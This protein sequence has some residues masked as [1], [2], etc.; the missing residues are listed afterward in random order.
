MVVAGVFLGAAGAVAPNL[1]SSKDKTSEAQVP[2]QTSVPE[3]KVLVE[4]T[5]DIEKKY[6]TGVFAHFK[7]AEEANQYLQDQEKQAGYHRDTMTLD[8]LREH[9]RSE[10]D[11]R[12]RTMRIIISEQMFKNF[13]L[14][15]K[16][17]YA[18]LK[19]QVEELNTIYKNAG[20]DL[21]YTM[22]QIIVIDW[23]VHSATINHMAGDGVSISDTEKIQYSWQDDTTWPIADDAE[24]DETDQDIKF[25]LRPDGNYHYPTLMH[26]WVHHTGMNDLY[27]ETGRFHEKHLE[28]IWAY[29]SDMMSVSATLT[30]TPASTLAINKMLEQEYYGPQ[31]A[32]KLTFGEY[33]DMLWNYTAQEYS[34]TLQDKN[35]NRLNHLLPGGVFFTGEKDKANYFTDLNYQGVETSDTTTILNRVDINKHMHTIFN[36]Q[37]LMVPLDRRHLVYENMYRQS[38]DGPIPV[39]ITVVADPSEVG[40]NT[41][42]SLEM[43]QVGNEQPEEV[44]FNKPVIA[45]API[46]NTGIYSVWLRG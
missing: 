13:M 38:G 36:I 19:N 46:G 43:I 42:V 18:H 39:T 37:E 31:H 15:G 11:H 44:Y 28:R 33:H 32:D 22:Q 8:E 29:V 45:Y 26:E 3:V 30:L 9:R 5:R 7:T 16:D 24:N 4:P 6:E 1:L 12:H 17:P 40:T 25:I 14:L 27:R 23:N 41:T 35:G 20:I 21:Q 34:V 2:A 10:R